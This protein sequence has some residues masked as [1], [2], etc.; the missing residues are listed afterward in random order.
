[1]RKFRTKERKADRKETI[2]VRNDASQSSGDTSVLFF[3]VSKGRDR[4]YHVANVPV[5]ERGANG[6]RTLDKRGKRGR[7]REDA[8]ET[9]R[10]TSVRGCT[11][12]RRRR[13]VKVVVLSSDLIIY[14]AGCRGLPRRSSPHWG[15]KSKLNRGG[16]MLLLARAQ[17][18]RFAVVRRHLRKRPPSMI[19]TLLEWCSR[20]SIV[21]CRVWFSM[22]FFECVWGLRS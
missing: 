2:I 20:K 10:E 14:A 21:P 22:I 18:S 9:R 1:M 11:R 12:S 17:G 13:C 6:A 7:G 4:L 5:A 15:N 16:W 8:R 19:I 3:I